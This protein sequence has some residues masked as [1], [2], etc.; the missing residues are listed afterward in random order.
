V[1][2]IIYSHKNKKL[3]PKLE[4]THPSS[5]IHLNPIQFIQG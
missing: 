3:N 2:F 4:R 1:L 5:T